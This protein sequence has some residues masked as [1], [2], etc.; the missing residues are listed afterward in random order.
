MAT[1]NATTSFVVYTNSETIALNLE[2]HHFNGI[3]LSRGKDLHPDVCHFLFPVLFKL[4]I[5]K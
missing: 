1:N 4:L 3:T 2:I 5:D